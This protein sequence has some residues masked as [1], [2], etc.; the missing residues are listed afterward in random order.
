MPRKTALVVIDVQVGIFDGM[1]AYRFDE[2][3]RRIAGLLKLARDAG[4]PVIY[5]QQ[6]GAEGHRLHPSKPGWEIHPAIKPQAGEP[7][8]HKR[9]C[10]SF[11]ETTLQE[12]LQRRQINHLV[13]AGC[14]T[15]Y[16]VDTT[17]RRAVSLGYD[18]TL[19]GDAHTTADT[20]RLSA[21][22][23]VAHHNAVLDGLSAGAHAI[24]IKPAA[25]VALAARVA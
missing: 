2:V 19:A 13:V 23:I 7:I 12:E 9:E 11:F 5:V 18:V 3:V 20:E 14:M 21:A 16:C 10:D 1:R 22:Q 4:T 15:E 6:S 24:E 25:E 8:V 17:C